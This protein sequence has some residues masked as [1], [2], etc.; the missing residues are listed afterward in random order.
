MAP[1]SWQHF[2]EKAKFLGVSLGLVMLYQKDRMR[3]TVPEVV[4]KENS[5]C[6]RQKENLG[7]FLL[8]PTCCAICCFFS[9]PENDL[10]WKGH[11][12]IVLTSAETP[13]IN[14]WKSAVY[15][16][17]HVHFMYLNICSVSPPRDKIRT[18]RGD[19][20][21]ERGHGTNPERMRNATCKSTSVLSKLSH[22]V[23]ILIP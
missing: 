11:R 12:W 16:A 23:R 17:L 18:L 1:W 2:L 3:Q 5:C 20:T 9:H 14:S 8:I 21:L 10:L 15:L 19:L 13:A 7:L 22:L 6:W 4:Q